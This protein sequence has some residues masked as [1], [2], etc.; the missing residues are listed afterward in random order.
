MHLPK[1]VF[2][3]TDLE[4]A[5]GVHRFDQACAKSQEIRA[6]RRELT[7][8]LNAVVRGINDLDKG[9][10]VHVWDGHGAGGLVKEELL[11]VTKYLPPSRVDVPGYFRAERIDAL[12]FVGQHAMSGTPGAN[13]CHT[14]SHE[15]IKHYKLN[16]TEVGE[17][18]VWAAVAGELGVPTVYLSGD[19]KACAEATRHVPGIITTAVKES[20]ELEQAIDLPDIEARLHNDIQV[21]LR[22]ADS[23]RPFDIGKPVALEIAVY[24]MRH[25][26]RM[27]KR[28]AKLRGWKE[29]V[30]HAPSMQDLLAR[31]II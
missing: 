3:I 15:A 16:G 27:I 19:D 21:A 25:V 30:F 29:A 20:K 26:G 9:I 28:G 23:V 24:R 6:A 1:N 8:E 10:R 31:G 17:F 2:I 5:A 12:A 18:G 14:M 4:G 7:R 22:G 13:L 11:P